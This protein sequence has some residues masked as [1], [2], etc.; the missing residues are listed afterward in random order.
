MLDP[1]DAQDPRDP[2][3]E[4]FLQAAA[5]GQA[6]AH[7]VPVARIAERARRAHRRRVALAAGAACLVLAGGGVTA[8]ALLSDAPTPVV[9]AVSPSADAPSP[10]ETTS[11]PL[12]SSTAP[13]SP[14]QDGPAGDPSATTDPSGRVTTSPP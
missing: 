6:R 4:M 12:S 10:G 2:L 3:R 8:A 7:A 9:P 11:P 13:G 5:F 1:Q 14:T